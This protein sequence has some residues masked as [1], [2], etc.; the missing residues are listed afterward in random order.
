MVLRYCL[1]AAGVFATGLWGA[2]YK[3]P[4]QSLESTAMAAASIASS[5]GASRAYYNPASMVWLGAGNHTEVGVTY[6]N[7]P[8]VHYADQSTPLRNG[9]SLAEN[10]LIPTLHWAKP[11]DPAWAVGMSIAAPA[12]LSKR[13]DEA[14]P[15]AFAQEFT[16]RVMELNPTLAYKISD[17]VAIAG[18]VRA[19]YSDGVVRS[20]TSAS[21]D[22]K[23]DSVDWGYNIALTFVPSASWSL[24]A[25]Y[26][27]KV[28][29][30]VDGD[31][32]LFAGATQVYNGGASVTIPLPATLAL[33]VAHTFSDKL[34]V[35]AVY[36]KTYWSEYKE[37]DFNYATPIYAPLKS[38]FDD[39]KPKKWKDS[40][41]YR[42]GVKYRYTPDLILMGGF[43]I[44][45]SPVPSSTVGFELPD[46]DAKLYSCGFIKKITPSLSWGG[47]YLYDTKEQR[48]ATNTAGVNG[49]F[50]DAQAHMVRLSLFYRY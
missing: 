49:T 18:G 17:H 35:E 27:S 26:R 6:I 11:L 10:F 4:E 41:T 12:G 13:W 48:T 45:R 19:V 1:V 8:K 3:I 36:E 38:A 50:T 29:L 43:A 25:T 34:T 39:P 32:K 16:L 22:M 9:D 20:S 46:S 14:Y 15:K 7:L 47:A 37:L 28:N 31:A 33:A 40:D 23:G 2:G 44:D 42:V 24:A 5:D 30:T 21:R